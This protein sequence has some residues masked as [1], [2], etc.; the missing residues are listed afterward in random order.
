MFTII[1]CCL[2]APQA[3]DHRPQIKLATEL[4][5]RFYASW[6]AG[7]VE[8]VLPLCQMPWYHDGL[9]VVQQTDSLRVELKK[10]IDARD[11]SHGKRTVD[12]KLVMTYGATKERMPSKERALLDQVMRDDDYLVLVMLKPADVTVKKSE[13]VVLLTRIKD[14]KAMAVG[15]KHTQ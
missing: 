7:N 4:A 11:V 14:G 9:Q 13:N 10:L 5:Q 1:L 8:G 6:E 12:V 3:E 15:I 2:L